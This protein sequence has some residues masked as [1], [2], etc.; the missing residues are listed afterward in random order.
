[1]GPIHDGFCETIYRGYVPILAFTGNNPVFSFSV[2]AAEA[3]FQDAFSRF[4]PDTSRLFVSGF[5]GGS[6]FASNLAIQDPRVKGVIACGAG[7]YHNRDTQPQ[8]P[9][10][11]CYYGIMGCRDMNLPDMIET[12]ER[13]SKNGIIY[14]IQSIDI[15]HEWPPSEEI[16]AAVA[17]LAYKLDSTDRDA[18]DFYFEFQAEKIQSMEEKGWYADAAERV[19]SVLNDSADPTIQLHL[20]ELVSSK[21][22]RTQFRQ[23]EKA[24]TQEQRLTATYLDALSGFVY[25]TNARPDTVHTPQWWYGEIDKLK[26]WEGSPDIETSRLASR[27]LYLLEVHFSEDMQMYISKL[28]LVKALFIA[29]LWLR[30]APDQLWSLWDVAALYTLTGNSHQAIRL[31]EQMISSGV[32]R[33]DWFQTA[34][35]FIRLVF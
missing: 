17:W 27:L 33:P 5:S 28:Q 2:E 31:I 29:D 21:E 19:K 26:R 1:M 25:S 35:E 18:K 9:G 7:M 16:T 30:I 34:P 8:I 11:F 22:T 6:R 13:L 10:T 20:N 3:L 23:R 4:N 14:H 15:R 24:Y 12:R 32:A